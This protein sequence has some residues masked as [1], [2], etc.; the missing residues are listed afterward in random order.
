MSRA[1]DLEAVRRLL[2]ARTPS[3]LDEPGGPRAAVAT[4]LREGAEGLEVLLIRRAQHPEDPW[5]GHMAFP[6][7][8]QDS[9][10]PDLLHT[11]LRETLDGS[12]TLLGR[13]DDVPAV[14]RGERTG[15]VI[16]PFVFELAR[17]AT[18]RPNHEVAETLWA[19]LSP[20]MRGE[21]DTVRPYVWKGV[22]LKLPAYDVAGRIVWG[23]TYQMLHGLF[24]ILA[25]R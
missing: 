15:M 8:R 22:D 1:H 17:E 21:V 24:G 10:D 20:M 9:G 23:L 16:S 12:R 5:S 3:T 7:G 6:G 11:A 4:V 2:S 19:P 25:E 18:L 13:L 14:A